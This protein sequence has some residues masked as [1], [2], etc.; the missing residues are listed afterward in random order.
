MSKEFHAE[1]SYGTNRRKMYTYIGTWIVNLPFLFYEIDYVK[2]KHL[3]QRSVSDLSYCALK[4]FL[5]STY[6]INNF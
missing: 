3:E 4:H 1:K 2:S 5:L 6:N